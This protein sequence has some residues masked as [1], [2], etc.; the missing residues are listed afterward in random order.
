MSQIAIRFIERPVRPDGELHEVCAMVS[1][2]LARRFV[3]RYVKG[4]REHNT[5]T[6]YQ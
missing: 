5:M 2:L 1:M 3:V 6:Q 4:L